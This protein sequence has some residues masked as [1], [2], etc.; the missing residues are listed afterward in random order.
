MIPDTEW[1][2]YGLVW[3]KSTDTG[4]HGSK[5]VQAPQRIKT[6]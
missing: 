5:G 1:Y 6:E 3:N 4:W 2:R